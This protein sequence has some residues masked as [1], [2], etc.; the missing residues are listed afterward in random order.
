MSN[1]VDDCA[2]TGS[3]SD[4]EMMMALF[5]GDE[6]DEAD[7]SDASYFLNELHRDEGYD[8]VDLRYAEYQT[9]ESVAVPSN[10][11]V[12]H[13]FRVHYDDDGCS[14]SPIHA[15]AT[16]DAVRFSP[17]P[18]NA[19][20]DTE[21][22]NFLAV[23]PSSEEKEMLFLPPTAS[24]TIAPA[25]S[26]LPTTTCST[27]FIHGWPFYKTNRNK[28][29][30]SS[31]QSVALQL[32][33]NIKTQY[34][35]LLVVKY[36]EPQR[37]G[38]SVAHFYGVMTAEWL[39]LT[40]KGAQNTA[41]QKNS[42]TKGVV[43]LATKHCT[44]LELI[45]EGQSCKLHFDVDMLS[46]TL[47]TG[48]EKARVVT[49]MQTLLFDT[50]CKIGFAPHCVD[51]AFLQST[52]LVLDGSRRKDDDTFKLSLHIIY[53]SVFVTDNHYTMKMLYQAMAVVASKTNLLY[54]AA[55]CDVGF[56]DKIATKNR[57]FRLPYC[58]VPHSTHESRLVPSQ[59]IDGVLVPIESHE[60]A[61]QRYW[62]SCDYFS[63]LLDHDSSV[64][65]N[66]SDIEHFFRDSTNSTTKVYHTTTSDIDLNCV[67]THT[68]FL[69]ETE[70]YMA[71]RSFEL[72]VQLRKKEGLCSQHV[73]V[74]GASQM[75]QLPAKPCVVYLNVPGDDYCEHKGRVH[76][77]DNGTQTGFGL[78]L[79][80]MVAWQTCFS[81]CPVQTIAKVNQKQYCLLS[82]HNS[83]PT[84][85][86]RNVDLLNNIVKNEYNTAV[87]FLAE[88]RNLLYV[89]PGKRAPTL[90]CWN[91]RETL[92][93]NDS[94]S[95]IWRMLPVWINR[96]KYLVER[97]LSFQADDEETQKKLA[98]W[99][100]RFHTADG[101]KAIRQII[102]AL[103]EDRTFEEKLNSHHH[104]I[105]T[106][107]NKV[108]DIRTGTLRTR[109][110]TDFFSM[111]MK[112]DFIPDAV[113][114]VVDDRDGHK[115]FEDVVFLDP[116]VLA[117]MHHIE[118]LGC[119]NTEWSFF[120]WNLL[121]YFITGY[122]QDR[123]WVMMQGVGAN[124]KSGLFTALSAVMGPFYTTVSQDFFTVSGTKQQAENASPLM[125]SLQWV[126]ALVVAETTSGCKLNMARLKSLTGPDEQKCR[127]L[128]Q[129]AAT[130]TPNVK[131]AII[132]NFALEIDCS[133]QAAKD[134]HL[135]IN[136]AQRYVKCNPGPNEVLADTV[137]AARLATDLLGAFGT[138]LCYGAHTMYLQTQS[139]AHGLT[140]PACIQEFVE[141]QLEE[142]DLISAFV[143]QETE[144]RTGS[145]IR[146]IDM[147]AQFTAWAKHRRSELQD[148]VLDAFVKQIQS[149]SFQHIQYKKK[150]DGSA[151]FVG[152]RKRR[153]FAERSTNIPTEEESS[154]DDEGAE[155]S[156]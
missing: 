74:P 1:F 33:N 144:K 55:T 44:L 65:I 95:F 25:V 75:R 31:P 149:K 10:R 70:W 125:R 42:P 73:R 94:S 135:A 5:E 102:C 140:R 112:F 123:S 113:E 28:S 58:V 17:P 84:T 127:G 105:P 128:Y 67:V 146:C 64:M 85:I 22:T 142:S 59:I 88:H 141:R 93:V 23:L 98:A 118:E 49:D 132:S 89:T 72:L 19:V 53:E 57:V 16:T 109:T 145:S 124:G 46:D 78:C 41:K 156:M 115:C 76:S 39:E 68:R 50:L 97:F 48:E 154:S 134:R 40:I 103:A 35:R 26:C 29:G 61:M 147:W 92:W 91:E 21:I 139:C 18:D 8:D 7:E 130:F 101:I 153:F 150:S 54:S 90:W 151:C 6:G 32:Y 79:S 9:D 77:N 63:T 56:D 83:V 66:S 3:P 69:T 120:M 116:R 24:S 131:I 14:L 126:R 30:G 20:D 36:L 96:K 133:D 108:F 119:H 37:N 47:P 136:F 137:K 51:M 2:Q 122:T 86:D 80:T 107:N 138:W 82:L 13:P 117:V 87:L 45:P 12:D 104:L 129:D 27:K 121:G 11:D 106:K 143:Y 114:M 99:V 81:C 4:E 38:R 15:D 71:H 60:V 62:V 43:K 110:M 52:T 111:S 100:T 34:E 148:I 155:Y 152:I